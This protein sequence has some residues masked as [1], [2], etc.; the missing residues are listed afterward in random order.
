MLRLLGCLF[1]ICSFPALAFAKP[2]VVIEFFG[3][4]G[5]SADTKAQENLERVVLENENIILLNCRDWTSIKGATQAFSNALCRERKN[6]YYKGFHKAVFA[7]QSSL[8]V[9]G[10][11]DAYYEDIM[12]AVKLGLTDNLLSLDLTKRDDVLDVAIPDVSGRAKSAELYIF[13][14]KT[15]EDEKVHVVD[16]DVELTEDLQRKVISNRSVPFVTEVRKSQLYIRPIVAIK[17]V[18]RFD[19]RGDGI[20]MQLSVPLSDMGTVYDVPRDELSYVA[21]MYKDGPYGPVLAAGEIMSAS[22]K[23]R[24]Y[25]KST[26]PDF[27]FVSAPIDAALK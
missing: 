18:G 13:A 9:N 6:G 11:W 16:A 1:I 3:V 7:P 21:V 24:Q 27:E 23:S 20:S 19:A 10:Q 26:A 8:F 5:C 4:N 22:E 12:P 14:Y 25:P 2:P 15:S 17:H